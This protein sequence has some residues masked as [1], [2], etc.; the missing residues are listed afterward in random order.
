MTLTRGMESWAIRSCISVGPPYICLTL[1]LTITLTVSLGR[2]VIWNYGSLALGPP[3]TFSALAQEF[4]DKS[5]LAGSTV[6]WPG[7]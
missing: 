1:T 7:V 4:G 2:V 6:T 3:Y 5:V